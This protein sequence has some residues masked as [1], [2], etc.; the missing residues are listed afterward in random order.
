MATLEYSQHILGQGANNIYDDI[1]N[2][3]IIPPTW[4]DN[5]RGRGRPLESVS[6]EQEGVRGVNAPPSRGYYPGHFAFSKRTGF[7]D[8]TEEKLKL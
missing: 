1:V 5:Q 3:D 8:K 6:T 2:C 4:K 7:I